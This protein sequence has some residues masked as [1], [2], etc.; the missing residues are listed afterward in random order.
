MPQT[1]EQL[2]VITASNPDAKRHVEKSIANSIDPTICTQHFDSKVLDEVMRTSADGKFYAWGAVPGKKNQPNWSAMR[3]GDHVLVYQEGRYTYW[4]RVIS[5]HRNAPFAE[6]LWGRDPQ[7][8]TWEFMYFLRTPVP[9]QCAAQVTADV[10]PAQYMGFTPITADRVQRIVSQYGSVERFVEG[11]MK[12]TETY[13]MFRSNK[14][15]D[16][17]DEEGQSYHYGNT[18]ANYTVVTTGAKFLLDRVF[19]EGKRIIGIGKIGKIT[20]EPGTGKATR[21]FRASYEEYQPLRPPRLLT[22]EDESTL[23]SLDGF[24]IQH[25]IHRITKPVFEKLG[26]PAR[27]WIFQSNPEYYDVRGALAVLKSDTCLVSRYEDKIEIGDRVYLW[28]SGKDA[29]IVGVGEVIDA[30]SPRPPLPESVPFQRDRERFAGDRARVL[31]RFLGSVEPPLS[32]HQIQTVPGLSDLS[33][34][35]QPQGTN[36][37]V[38]PA[39]AEAIEE[40]LSETKE[41]TNM[42]PPA[43]LSESLYAQLCRETFLPESFFADCEHLLETQKQIILQGAPGTGKTF[44]AEKLAAWWAGALERTRTVQFHESYGYEDF[45]KGIKPVYNPDKEETLFRPTEGVF[46][47]FCDSARKGSG[48]RYVLVIDEINRA[49][50]SRVFGELLYLLEYRN[51]TATLQSGETFSIPDQLYII[52]TMNTADKSIA[53]VD[54]ALRRRFA[55]VTLQPVDGDKSVVLRAW[56]DANQIANAAE[57]ER[58]FVT[59]NKLIAAKD[60]ALMIGHSYFMMQEAVS[61]KRYPNDLLEFLWRYRILPLVAEYEY[62][63]SADQ[64]EE[65]YGLAAVSRLAGLK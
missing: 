36:F 55:F 15:S 63:L 40:L 52:G 5:T 47:S 35:K 17:S 7:G 60:E 49:K 4:A 9:L 51:R 65:K 45:V 41:S 29:G 11:R 32:R 50:V 39:E 28:E 10:L 19:P 20:D 16:W 21:T 12:G 1:Q 14:G 6:A 46:L 43:P 25:S 33:I 37:I 34:L 44:V 61:K 3:A 30:T 23:A 22:P 48:D 38:T 56:M 18:V 64:I 2:F 42:E 24:N 58:L 8:Q 62:E 57:V 59:L 53:L 54:Y 26:H 13:L 27:A 31:L